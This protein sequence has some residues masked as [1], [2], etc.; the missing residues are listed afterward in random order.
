MRLKFWPA[1]ADI[2]TRG[3]IMK[4]VSIERAN[5]NRRWVNLDQVVEITFLKDKKRVCLDFPANQIIVHRKDFDEWGI[6]CDHDSA[7]IEFPE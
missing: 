2:K 6:K 4:I 5:G 1:I 7:V 3:P